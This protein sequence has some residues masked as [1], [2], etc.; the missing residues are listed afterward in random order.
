MHL[1]ISEGEKN[2]HKFVEGMAML[3][4]NIAYLCHT[5]GIEI[6]LNHKVTHTMQNLVAC[7]NT[8]LPSKLGV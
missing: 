6:P 5:Q 1:F 2:Y 7:L 3:N 4:Y 8:P